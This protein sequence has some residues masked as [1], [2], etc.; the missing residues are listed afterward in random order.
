MNDKLLSIK[1][2]YNL[3]LSTWQSFDENKKDDFLKTCI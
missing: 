1:L 3:Q 2:I